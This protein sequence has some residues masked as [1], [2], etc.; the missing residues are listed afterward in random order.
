MRNIRFIALAALLGTAALPTLAL[1]SGAKDPGVPTH[2]TAVYGPSQAA[3][4]TSSAVQAAGSASSPGVVY[5]GLTT[6]KNPIMLQLSRTHR[7]VVRTAITW[8]ANCSNPNDFFFESAVFTVPMA[9]QSNGK[10][11]AT[12]SRNFEDGPGITATESL[13]ITGT[14]KK[15]RLITGTATGSLADKDQSGK[16]VEQCNSG[17]LRYT[18]IQ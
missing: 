10:F 3:G 8:E 13:T 4:A 7:K 5:G 15:D 18:A 2:G 11:A 1:A 12:A 6:Q 17:T 9:I 16:V 14:L